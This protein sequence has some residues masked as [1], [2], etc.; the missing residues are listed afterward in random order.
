[1]GGF[2]FIPAS[3]IAA[4]WAFLLGVC[5]V[6]S[7]LTFLETVANPY[8]TVLGPQRYAAAR[9]QRGPV[10]QRRRVDLWPDRGQLMFFYGTDTAGRSTGSQTLWIPYAGVAVAVLVLS[11]IFFFAPVPDVKAEDD[12]RMDDKDKTATPRVACGT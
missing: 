8:T 4:F 7:G 9:D 3:K 12:Y 11:V 6:A 5:V 2:W 1:M 10:M